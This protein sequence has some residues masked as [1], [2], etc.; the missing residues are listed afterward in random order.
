MTI[1]EF[2]KKYTDA[3]SEKIKDQMLRSRVK[4]TYCPIIEKRTILQI[5][6]DNSIVTTDVGVKYID[7]TTS[8]INYTMSL[9]ALYT[10]LKVD[11]NDDG[12][13][14][15]NEDYDALIESGLVGKICEIIGESE[16]REFASINADII[17]NFQA[18]QGSLEAML[19]RF[20][21]VFSEKVG[22]AAGI[23]LENMDRI[24]PKLAEELK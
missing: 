23:V 13:G 7:M 2:V 6:L 10:D 21:V 14:M 4:R 8:R 15:I 5:M 11:S 3:N 17:Q 1:L 22:V 16:L 20:L 18:S 9:I 24:M 19:A 12:K